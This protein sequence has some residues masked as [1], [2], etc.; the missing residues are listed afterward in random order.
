MMDQVTHLTVV[1]PARTLA[2]ADRF[3][4]LVAGGGIAGVSAAVAA[5]RNGASVCLL[6]RMFA[7]GGLATL[8]NVTAW[9]PL[10]D[11][12]GRQVCGGLAEEMLILSVADLD[13]DNKRARF[14]GIPEAWLPDGDPAERKG[15]RYMVH[16]I[17]RPI[18]WHWSAGP[19]TAV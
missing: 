17:H 6:E 8:G 18:C 1:E 2:V 5:A 4:V 3:D 14:T 13:Q 16:F 10:C 12:M 7:L 11:G 19:S 15:K 9:L